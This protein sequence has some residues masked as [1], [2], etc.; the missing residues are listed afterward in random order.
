MS[1]GLCYLVSVSGYFGT[2]FAE[3]R[4]SLG[5]YSR[6]KTTEFSF[7]FSQVL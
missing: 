7:Y 1:S 5:R 2:N 4:R 6:T 3:N